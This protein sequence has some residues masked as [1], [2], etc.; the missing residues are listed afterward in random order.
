MRS[1]S[2]EHVYTFHVIKGNF[3]SIDTENF[4]MISGFDSVLNLLNLEF[5][6][7]QHSTTQ[8]NTTRNKA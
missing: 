2:N 8:H 5:H 1:K 4:K 3:G 6:Q 7:A